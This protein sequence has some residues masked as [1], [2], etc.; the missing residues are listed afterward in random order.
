[1][2][3]DRS[4]APIRSIVQVKNNIAACLLTDGKLVLRN[5]NFVPVIALR[6]YALA[7]AKIREHL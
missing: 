6:T 1:M 2:V 3:G 4:S 7:K 5:I